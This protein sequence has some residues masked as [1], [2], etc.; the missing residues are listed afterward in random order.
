MQGRRRVG[1]FCLKLSQFCKDC[2][3][4]HLQVFFVKKK[5]S[6]S[7]SRKANLP[8]KRSTVCSALSSLCIVLMQ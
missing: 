3:I 6:T 7:M 4:E 1:I 2:D 5:Q 8:A